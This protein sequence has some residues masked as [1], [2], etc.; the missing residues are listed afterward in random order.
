[1]PNTF[2]DRFNLRRL[3]RLLYK[4]RFEQQNVR[5]GNYLNID[6][7]WLHISRLNYH[8]IYS[9]PMAY[10]PQWALDQFNPTD[11]NSLAPL[12]ELNCL[13][14]THRQAMNFQSHQNTLFSVNANGFM[15][16][17]THGWG[18]DIQ[19]LSDHSFSPFF[20][21][22]VSLNDNGP[23]LSHAHTIDSIHVQ[24]TVH[25]S[26]EH[27]VVDICL[28]FHNTSYSPTN[29]Q[30]GFGIVPFTNEGVGCLKEIQYLSTQSFI[31]NDSSMIHLETA[32]DNIVCTNYADGNI[33]KIS[34]SW[35]MILHSTCSDFMASGLAI[36]DLPLSADE[37]KSIRFNICPKKS[38]ITPLI[39]P[40]SSMIKHRFFN[41]N[42]PSFSTEDSATSDST[43]PAS[44]CKIQLDDLP[45]T[46]SVFSHFL[47]SIRTPPSVYESVDLYFGLK[48]LSRLNLPTYFELFSNYFIHAKKITPISYLTTK[49]TRLFNHVLILSTFHQYFQ[50][51]LNLDHLDHQSIIKSLQSDHFIYFLSKLSIHQFKEMLTQSPGLQLFLKLLTY[52]YMLDQLLLDQSIANHAY[53]DKTRGLL[54]HFF[55]LIDEDSIQ[56]LLMQFLN[57]SK[58]SLHEQYFILNTIL[59]HSISASLLLPIIDSLTQKY[60]HQNAY[61]NPMNYKGYC[62]KEAGLFAHISPSN[63]R[64][65]LLRH[66]FKSIDSFGNYNHPNSTQHMIREFPHIQG[67]H[68]SLYLNLLFNHLIVCTTDS[69]SIDALLYF[70]HGSFQQ[71]NTIFG[72]INLSFK[73]EPNCIFVD[74]NHVFHSAPDTLCLKLPD[75]IR[76]YQFENDNKTTI[77]SN[78]F[79]I[80]LNKTNVTLFFN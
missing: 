30:F 60:W 42:T 2:I 16:F 74:I 68:H 57:L 44:H 38:F 69:I 6:S 23:Y 52:L 53:I 15:A 17:P 29:I 10:W 70:D 67:N 4:S 62:A 18:I 7:K 25:F 31:L 46:S 45:K 63:E 75:H 66:Y 9:N 36:Y 11:Q 47:T 24:S 80:P 56:S 41:Q 49:Q 34:Q 3:Q 26:I 1:M 58:S 55:D 37:S 5:I 13:N 14:Q 64:L 22:D 48:S 19:L 35:D 73:S 65:T 8:Y 33:F 59:P 77:K 27:D 32:P 43:Y 54:A 40:L 21:S 78:D 71:L 12:N 61:F 20:K 72:Q 76:S 50:L 28:T 79:H 39:Y 51:K